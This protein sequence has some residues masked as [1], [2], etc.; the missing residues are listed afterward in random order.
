MP[1][2]DG[3]A[4]ELPADI[5]LVPPRELWRSTLGCQAWVEALLPP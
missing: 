4:R 1:W 3:G 2:Q 5:S